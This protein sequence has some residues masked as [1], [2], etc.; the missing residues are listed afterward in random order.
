MFYDFLK[1]LHVLSIIVWIGGMVYTLMFLR[2]SVVGLEPPLRVKLMHDVLGRFFKAVL[3]LS[4]VAVLSGFWMVGRVA[5][6]AVQAGG[7][8]TWPTAWVVMAVLGVIMFLIFAHIRFALYKR[9]QRAVAAAD[10]PSGGLA[11]E[12]IRLWVSVNLV[13]GIVIVAAVFLLR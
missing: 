9:L 7:S 2:P 13:V 3:L 12:Q 11:L 10:W 4:S 1:L 8:Y 5:K 6:Q